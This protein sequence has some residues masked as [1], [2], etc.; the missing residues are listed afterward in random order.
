MG[1]LYNSRI[2]T[3]GLVLCLDAGDRVS[4]PGAGTTWTDLTANKNNMTLYN[5]PSFTTENGGAVVFDGT[6][7]YAQNINTNFAQTSNFT[8]ETS[9]KLNVNLSAG[10]WVIFS[11]YDGSNGYQLVWASSY[12]YFYRG[13]IQLTTVSLSSTFFSGD[14]LNLVTVWDNSNI[15]NCSILINNEDK[16]DTRNSTSAS[17]GTDPLTFNRRGD[18]MAF[19]LGHDMHLFRFY[20]RAL[21]AEEIRQNYNATKGRFGL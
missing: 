21:S 16:T 11:T 10:T 9:V 13:G 17:N 4:Y 1:V 19:P 20:N 3:D 7:D 5:G 6:D 8:V 12:F 14:I 18:L 15:N 2:V